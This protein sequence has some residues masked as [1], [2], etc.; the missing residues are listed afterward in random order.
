LSYSPIRIIPQPKSRTAE[1]AVSELRLKAVPRFPL[2]A[3]PV[4][5][6]GC[7]SRNNLGR[8]AAPDSAPAKYRHHP[9]DLQA[10]HTQE[11][12]VSAGPLTGLDE[13]QVFLD[14]RESHVF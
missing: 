9:D 6:G 10:G 4:E 12:M 5:R 11:S 8:W 2:A 3:D 14:R 1:N 13:H 7:T